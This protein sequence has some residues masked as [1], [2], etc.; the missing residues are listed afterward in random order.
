MA[1]KPK[2]VSLE[3]DEPKSSEPNEQP[4]GVRFRFMEAGVLHFED[5]SQYHIQ[6]RDVR[7]TDPDL[8]ENLRQKS[9]DRSYKIH[10]IE[11]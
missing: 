4:D 9:K 7:I 5:G 1:A 6:E 11:D 3:S 2:I 8:I 10:I